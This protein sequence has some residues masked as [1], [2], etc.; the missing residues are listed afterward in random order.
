MTITRRDM[1]VLVRSLGIIE[2]LNMVLTA[3][4]AITACPKM[5][6]PEVVD[7]ARQFIEDTFTEAHNAYKEEFG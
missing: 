1:H 6:A 2:A 4:Q 5:Y 7:T 3:A